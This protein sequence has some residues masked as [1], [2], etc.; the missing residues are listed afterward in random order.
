LKKRKCISGVIFL[1]N[2]HISLITGVPAEPYQDD[3]PNWIPTLHLGYETKSGDVNRFERK[4][5]REHRKL[6]TVINGKQ[7]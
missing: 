2:F 6:K 5:Q 3:A 4:Q 7:L 1:T